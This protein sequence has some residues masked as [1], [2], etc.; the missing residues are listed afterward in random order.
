ILGGGSGITRTL[1]LAARYAD[2]CNLFGTPSEVRD[3]VAALRRHCDAAGRE[4]IRVTHLST[5]VAER[6]QRELEA[7]LDRLSHAP[8]ELVLDHYG[9]GTVDIQTERYAA[10]ADAGVQT[11][12]VAMPDAVRPGALEVFAE[13]IERFR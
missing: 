13:V 12:I 9:A 7:T 3:R 6:T 8:S 4:L 2:A 5:A 1:K 11:A 10:L